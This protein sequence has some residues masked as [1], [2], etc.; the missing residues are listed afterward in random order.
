M[1]RRDFMPG[2]EVACRGH[3]FLL[4]VNIDHIATLREA[5][6]ATGLADPDYWK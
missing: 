5:R 6:N 2:G 3:F 4:F 1:Q